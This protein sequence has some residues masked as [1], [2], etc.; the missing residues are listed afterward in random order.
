MD[1][2]VPASGDDRTPCPMPQGGSQ[3]AAA[4]LCG[5]AVV[6]TKPGTLL[7]TM[8]DSELLMEGGVLKRQ[9]CPRRQGGP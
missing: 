4:L 5:G 7:S 1:P 8:V 3:I 9:A 2:G 6:G